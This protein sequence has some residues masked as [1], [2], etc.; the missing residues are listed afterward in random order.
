MVQNYRGGEECEKVVQEKLQDRFVSLLARTVSAIK[1]GRIE[2]SITVSNADLHEER[3]WINDHIKS[4]RTLKVQLK[5]WEFNLPELTM[6]EVCNSLRVL[7]LITLFMPV[8]MEWY[9]VMEEYR[10]IASSGAIHKSIQKIFIC[11]WVGFHFGSPVCS[12]PWAN[13]NS[14]N[15]VVFTPFYRQL[16]RN[17]RLRFVK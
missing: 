2:R 9:S 3:E 16:A 14:R 5:F 15:F 1:S 6:C 8:R 12:L 10:G 13:L 17:Y 11:S 7:S 4:V